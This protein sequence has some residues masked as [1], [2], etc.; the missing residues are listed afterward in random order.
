MYKN[1]QWQNDYIIDIRRYSL[2]TRN[3][4]GV[5]S[6]PEGNMETENNS[7]DITD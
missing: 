3:K 7:K 1:Q 5:K 6:E 4:M 2:G